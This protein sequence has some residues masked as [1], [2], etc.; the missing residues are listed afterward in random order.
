MEHS[1]FNKPGFITLSEETR[2]T[3]D[4]I[5]GNQ[6]LSIK[7]RTIY[8]MSAPVLTEKFKKNIM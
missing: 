1:E 4:R 7:I 6:D 8:R 3:I 2:Q 5:L